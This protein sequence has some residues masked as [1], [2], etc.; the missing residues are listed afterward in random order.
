MEFTTGPGLFPIFFFFN[1]R[2]IYSLLSPTAVCK[3]DSFQSLKC[4][5]LMG[6]IQQ[7]ENGK[8]STIDGTTEMTA[9]SC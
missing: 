6:P 7:D 9:L 8:S 2:I 3:S 4:F 5:L 1:D